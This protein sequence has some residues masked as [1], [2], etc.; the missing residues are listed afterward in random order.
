MASSRTQ[1]E[2]VAIARQE[3]ARADPEMLRQPGHWHVRLDG[4]RWDVGVQLVAGGF[5]EVVIDA[6]Q[7]KIFELRVGGAGPM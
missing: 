6:K 2:A 1:S 4:D 7:A 3:F 5:G